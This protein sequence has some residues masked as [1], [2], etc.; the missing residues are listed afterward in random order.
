MYV[1][2]ESGFE[3]TWPSETYSTGLSLGSIVDVVEIGGDE[4]CCCCEAAGEPDCET[5]CGVVD[6][7]LSP[8]LLFSRVVLA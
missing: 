1:T 6:A 7:R 5:G 4:G 8:D 2:P 3:T